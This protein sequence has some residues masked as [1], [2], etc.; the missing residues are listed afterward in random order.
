MLPIV[1]R[2]GTERSRRRELCFP[3]E[4]TWEGVCQEDI[5]GGRNQGATYL[6]KSV[7][8]IYRV[9]VVTLQIR[10]HDDLRGGK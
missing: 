6:V 10:E 9:D 2:G 3:V 5:L 1:Q 8:E 4:Q 7:A